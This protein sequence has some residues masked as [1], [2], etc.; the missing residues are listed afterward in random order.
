MSSMSVR[1]ICSIDTLSWSRRRRGRVGSGFWTTGS[2]VG[3]TGAG[4]LSAG[5]GVLMIAPLFARWPEKAGLDGIVATTDCCISILTSGPSFTRVRP[6]SGLLA[7]V[8][9]P[10]G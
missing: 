4:L 1:I 8:R 9:T 5:A 7:E 2:R 10:G 3:K 6:S